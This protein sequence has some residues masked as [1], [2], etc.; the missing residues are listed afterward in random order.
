MLLKFFKIFLLE[1]D[2]WNPDVFGVVGLLLL[3][4]LDAGLVEGGPEVGEIEVILLGQFDVDDAFVG[5]HQGFIETAID[6][7]AV[8]RVVQQLALD[9][10]LQ[11]LAVR[12]WSD[13]FIFTHI[14]CNR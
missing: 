8:Q 7:A 5:A 11:R 1:V 14:S 13:C 3:E 9:R 10:L 12:T 4:S 2:M 6:G